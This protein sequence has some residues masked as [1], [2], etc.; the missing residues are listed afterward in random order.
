VT[1]RDPVVVA[2]AGPAGLAAARELSAAGVDV[3]VCEQGARV[4]GLARTESYRGY[5]FDIGGHRFLSRVPEIQQQWEDTLGRDFLKV[6]RLSR[7]FYRGRFFDYPID[8]ANVVRNLGPWESLRI[9]ASYV[10]ERARRSRREDTLEA[11][12]T[13]RFGERL[14]RAFF[15]TYTEKVW[16]IPCSEIRADWA[17]QRIRG[18]TL[19]T[20]VAGALGGRSRA[21]SLAREFHY[22]RLGPGQMWER[23]ADLVVAAGGSVRLG[24]RVTRLHHDGRRVDRVE[25]GGAHAEPLSPAH[26]ISSLPLRHLLSCLDPAPP[27]DVIAAG[28]A[29]RHRDFILVGLIVDTPRTFPDTWVYVHSPEVLVG[30]I[31]NFR[32]WSAAMVPDPG[33]TSLGM[34][35]FCSVGDAVWSRSDPELIA[36]ATRELHTLGLAPGGR[37][38]DGCV[39][40]QEN[41]YPVYDGDYRANVAIVREYLG[42][43]ENLQT[44]GRSGTHRYN[45]QDHSMLTGRLAARNVLGGRHDVWDV[46]TERSYQDVS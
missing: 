44:I 36:L 9:V 22:P 46:N 5:R 31:Q 15:K 38:E 33:R 2:G 40:R 19:R 35:Y 13:S 42:R 23:F 27:A 20:T 1:G 16:G 8:L 39:I 7:I 12:V 21:A 14:Y 29:L 43:F 41:A 3:V 26:V 4:G 32:N 37:V 28:C 18:L 11:W 17:A 24:T 45:N 6:Q 25:I 34:E 10:R 30:R